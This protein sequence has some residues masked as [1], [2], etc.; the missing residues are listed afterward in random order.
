M[1]VGNTQTP[2]QNMW[3]A[4]MEHLQ[5]LIRETGLEC[6]KQM[7]ACCHIVIDFLKQGFRCCVQCR[8]Y[9]QIILRKTLCFRPQEI[10]FHIQFI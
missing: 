1:A 3:L 2:V 8:H 6:G 7:T 4:V 5:I 10:A 9:Q